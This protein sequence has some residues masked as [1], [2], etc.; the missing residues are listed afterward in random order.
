MNDY[1]E[2]TCHIQKDITELIK[3]LNDKKW[4]KAQA[5]TMN[6][7][8]DIMDLALWIRKEANK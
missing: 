1:S 3:A 2:V 8:I 4:K 7:G 6:I 5:I